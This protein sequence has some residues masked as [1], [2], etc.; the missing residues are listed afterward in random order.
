MG[1]TCDNECGDGREFERNCS[2]LMVL[3]WLF[4]CNGPA[5]R[6]RGW[7]DRA[8][9]AGRRTLEATMVALNIHRSYP[10]PTLYLTRLLHQRDGPL[11]CGCKLTLLY[12]LLPTMPQFLSVMS[13]LRRRTR[14]STL[15]T[16]RH[17]HPSSSL[18]SFFA[19]LRIDLSHHSSPISE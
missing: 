19:N 8:E 5:R 14:T 1:T 9:R 12:I 11:W 3:V 15:W 2:L 4:L 16:S 6:S 7:E 17:S 18:P 13:R 10:V